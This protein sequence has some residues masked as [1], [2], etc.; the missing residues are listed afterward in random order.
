MTVTAHQL[1]P[2]LDEVLENHGCGRAEQHLIANGAPGVDSLVEEIVAC[3]GLDDAARRRLLRYC[4]RILA[5]NTR[6]NEHARTAAGRVDE[7]LRVARHDQLNGGRDLERKPLTVKALGRTLRPALKVLRDP[8]AY[9]QLQVHAAERAVAEIFDSVP[10]C[11]LF[12]PSIEKELRR[13][14]YALLWKLH[15]QRTTGA[16]R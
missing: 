12:T 14:S 9:H 3:P 4:E 2:V 16:T 13:A 6:Q 8:D 7:L 5:L 10:P 11:H 1:S 15:G